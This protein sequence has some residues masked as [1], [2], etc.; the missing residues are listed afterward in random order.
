MGIPADKALFFSQ[1]YRTVMA[2]D[3]IVSYNRHYTFSTLSVHD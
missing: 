1:L 2:N 3:N